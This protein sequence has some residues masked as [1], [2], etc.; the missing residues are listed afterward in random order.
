MWKWQ[1]TKGGDFSGL[2]TQIGLHRDNAAGG[3][4]NIHAGAAIGKG[5]IGQLEV[6]H[7]YLGISVSGP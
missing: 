4:A 5:G 7:D 1:S 3:D 6:E 2:A